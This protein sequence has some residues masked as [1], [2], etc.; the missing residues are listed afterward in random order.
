MEP[1]AD[2]MRYEVFQEHELFFSSSAAVATLCPHHLVCCIADNFNSACRKKDLNP[3]GVTSFNI[4]HF[5]V[6]DVEDF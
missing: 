3:T 2:E 6:S 1:T 5:S 4:S